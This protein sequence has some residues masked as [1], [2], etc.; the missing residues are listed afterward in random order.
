MKDDFGFA[1]QFMGRIILFI[2]LLLYGMPAL[3]MVMTSLRTTEDTFRQAFGFNFVPTFNAYA[4]LPAAYDLSAALWS[5]LTITVV[6]SIAV[7]LLGVPAAYGLARMTGRRNAI[8]L[9]TLIVLQLLPA[10]TLVLPLYQ[11]LRSI[12]LLGTVP[13]VILA[14]VGH[15]L[16][17]AIVLLRPF[18]LAVPLDIEAAATLDG[19]SRVK[20]FFSVVL[21]LARNGVITVGVLVSMIIWGD[22]IFP[23]TLLVDPKDY[24][25]STLLA[26]QVGAHDINWPRLMA[27][28]ILT[29]LPVLLLF[30][31]TERRL[32][33]GLSMGGIK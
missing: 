15:T 10:S 30:L 31:A 29:S 3:F 22:F 17:F 6:S 2:A 23:I 12:G 16:P 32:V 1:S 26:Q 19:A 4:S 5:S 27:L 9:G 33:A 8:A 20:M 14:I 11:V 25:L 21:P 24:P 18:F 7:M 28:A 13:G